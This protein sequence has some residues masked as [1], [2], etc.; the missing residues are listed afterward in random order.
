MVEQPAVCLLFVLARQ[1]GQPDAV[2]DPKDLSKQVRLLELSALSALARLTISRANQAFFAEFVTGGK[3][4]VIK[5][6]SV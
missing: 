5:G 3:L 1:E 4:A 6:H 2:E